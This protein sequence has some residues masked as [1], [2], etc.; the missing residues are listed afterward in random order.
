MEPAATRDAADN[1][2]PT[3]APTQTATQRPLLEASR[4]GRRAAATDKWLLRDI[5]LQV[6]GGDRLAIVGPSGSGKSLLLR[7]LALLDPLDEGAI[8]WRGAP[9]GS[10]GVPDYRRQVMYLH[11]QPA[12]FEGDVEENLKQPFV[13]KIHAETRFNKDHVVELL[14]GVGRKPEFLQKRVTELSGGERQLVVLI[15]AM[16]LNPCVLLLDE[17]TASL[18]A[19]A[20]QA[21]EHLLEGWASGRG[22]QRA[23]VQVSHD[24]GQVERTAQRVF[25]MEAGTLKEGD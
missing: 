11:Q 21:V 5:T 3:A 19:D 7:A 15:R 10:R 17:P 4:V 18:D 6:N 13:L 8:T 16:Q 12:L 23:I 2:E 1:P 9:A 22:A 20:K 14:T 25:A 24:A